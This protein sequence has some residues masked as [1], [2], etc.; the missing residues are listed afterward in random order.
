MSAL[1]IDVYFISHVL[2]CFLLAV[3]SHC[4]EVLGKE[5][6]DKVQRYCERNGVP[7]MRSAI[8]CIMLQTIMVT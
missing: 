8:N 7:E 1:Y 5:K 2:F 4:L 3:C 6:F